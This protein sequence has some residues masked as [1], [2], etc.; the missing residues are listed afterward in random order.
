MADQLLSAH[1]VWS[2]WWDH[3]WYSGAPWF[4][5]QHCGNQLQSRDWTTSSSQPRSLT[6]AQ[7]ST[8][9]SSTTA[10]PQLP[11]KLI[12][13]THT[14]G[15]TLGTSTQTVQPCTTQPQDVSIL[16]APH[17]A[18]TTDASTQLPLI[19]FS[20]R[21]VYSKEPLD[22]AVPL[23]R[24][25]VSGSKDPSLRI[26]PLHRH[27]QR[28]LQHQQQQRSHPIPSCFRDCTPTPPPGLETQTLL[29]ISHNIP[30]N[31]APARRSSS[32]DLCLSTP[33]TQPSSQPPPALQPNVSTT[34]VGPHPSLFYAA[35]KS[36]ASTPLAGTHL[37]TCCRRHWF[38]GR[39]FWVWVWVWVR[40][41][42]TVSTALEDD[43]SLPNLALCLLHQCRAQSFCFLDRMSWTVN[44]N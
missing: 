27:H 36:A 1:A 26:V 25:N 41:G 28:S 33:G 9:T 35:P 21:C 12:V 39:G 8:L 2:T 19:E 29:G 16:A 7:A 42:A 3:S 17:S 11:L 43:H 5:A 44:R 23:H 31:A 38:G 14:T 13:S 37:A 22:C 10:A 4:S 32:N 6:L 34:Q 30:S 24:G 20:L 18:S 40:G 15:L